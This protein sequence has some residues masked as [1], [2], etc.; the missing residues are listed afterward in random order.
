[1]HPVDLQ[2]AVTNARD[3]ET[4]ELK[5]NHNQ[6]VN[7][8][9][10]RSSELDFKLKQFS[11]SINQKLE[12]LSTAATSN[13]STTAA[14]NNILDTRSS[15][16]TIKPSSNNIRK[17]QI[18]KDAQPNNPETNQQ[19]ILTSNI[20]PAI[21]FNDKSLVAIFP[22]EFEE[23]THVLLFS[24]AAFN[25]KPITTMYTD[26]KVDVD[27]AVSAHIIIA[28]GAT[29]TPIGEIDDFSFEVNSFII[30]IKVL[31]IEA[32]QY[33]ALVGNDWLSKTNT[34]L[35]WTIQELQF[36]QNGQYTQVPTT[37]RHFKLIIML[38][39]PLIEFE[40]E[41]EKPT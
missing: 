27:H 3:F 30:P 33:Q 7:L 8:V 18:K 31:V 12:G 26:A 25:T 5:A 6:T 35:N 32:T 20:P 4:A 11:D 38:S 37:C 28:D 40:E 9:I 39:A 17:F 29:K 10:N 34:I 41:K 24:R 36:S 2:V 1:M 19:S 13:I 21:I 22:F 15:N 16:T 14:T 23:T